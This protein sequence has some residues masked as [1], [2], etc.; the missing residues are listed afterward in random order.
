MME[1]RIISI[2]CRVVA[3]RG[4]D[5]PEYLRIA[6]ADGAMGELERIDQAATLDEATLEFERNEPA[7]GGHLPAN[8]FGLREICQVGIRDNVPQ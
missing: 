5:H 6:E 2:R 7:A 4:P 3:A 1:K 8:D